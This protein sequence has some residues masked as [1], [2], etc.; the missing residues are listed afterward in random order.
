MSTIAPSLGTTA[1][2]SFPGIV[3]GIDYNAI[4]SKLTQLSLAP[5][6]LLNAQ[7][8][9]LNNANAELIKISNLS[10]RCRTLSGIFRTRTCSRPIKRA[11]ASCG[12]F[13]H[14]H[15][16]RDRDAGTLHDRQRQS[17]DEYVD[18]FERKRRTLDYRHITS[19]TY[20]G[21][22]SERCRSPIHTQESRLER[23]NGNGSVTV[24]GVSD[25]LQRR[26]A[27]ARRDF[28]QYH[29]AGRLEGGCWFPRDAR[30]RR[31]RVHLERSADF[32]RQ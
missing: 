11:R 2:I 17:S 23:T 7:I 25:F 27:V 15:S 28:E 8:A 26:F 32:A 16:G 18:T 30:Q 12:A 22:A 20:A 1:P 5:T 10:R 4:I 31:R 13:G 6:T 3:S 21:Q 29:V 9:T 19:G 24:D 14:R